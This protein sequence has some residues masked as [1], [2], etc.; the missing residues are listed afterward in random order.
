MHLEAVPSQR[1][2]LLIPTFYH[3]R[4]S[5][6]LKP[7]QLLDVIARLKL[8]A[9]EIR[10]FTIANPGGPPHFAGVYEEDPLERSFPVALIVAEPI[11]H[12]V[13]PMIEEFV[14][15]LAKRYNQREI[16]CYSYYVIRY[17]PRSRGGS[18]AQAAAP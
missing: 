1:F 4:G 14:L 3:S 6:K 5:D 2:E 9:A 12:K 17:I 18:A 10:G 11:L 13:F 7:I 16:L 15:H 8:I